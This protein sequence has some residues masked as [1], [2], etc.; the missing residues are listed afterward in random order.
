MPKDKI[1]ER[2][3]K[4]LGLLSEVVNIC[5][6]AHIYD[7]TENYFRIYRKKPNLEEYFTNDFWKLDRI[8]S[9]I[10]NN[11]NLREENIIKDFENNTKSFLF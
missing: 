5:D 1:I 6:V 4:T 11:Q 7:N 8:Q 3:Y 10:L 9:L 2:Y